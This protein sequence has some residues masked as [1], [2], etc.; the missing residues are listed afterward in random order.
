MIMGNGNCGIAAKPW[1]NANDS[2]NVPQKKSQNEIVLVAHKK[3]SKMLT[4]SASACDLRFSDVNNGSLDASSPRG[5]LD[6]C[7]RGSESEASFKENTTQSESPSKSR[8]L[9]NWSRFFKLWK[10]KSTKHLRTF[11]PLAM[12]KLS[13]EK[14][15]S[16][17]EDPDLTHIYNYR[18]SLKE[19]TL[20]EL[21]TATKN[22]SSE[23]LIGKGGYAE[24]Y[25]GCLRDGTLV[26]VKRLTKG[27]V[28][29]KTCGF[30]CEIGSKDKPDWSKRYRIA[31][32][33]A[34]GLTYLH[35]GCQKRIIH[36]DIK[37]D[38]ILLTEDYEPQ[39]SALKHLTGLSLK[40]KGCTIMRIESHFCRFVILDLRSGCQDS[41]LTTTYFAPEYF[42][43]GIVDEKTDVYSFGVLLLELITGRRAV[44]HLQQSVVIWAKPLLDS[45][46]IRELVDPS[47]GDNYDAEEMDRAVLTASLCIE[48]SPILRPKMSQVVILL[49]GDEDNAQSV[50]ES[51]K[52]THRRT[53]S[54]ELF[55]AQEYN[56]T[57][58]LSDISRF[59]EIAL[60]S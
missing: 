56:S 22:F 45:N 49:R 35:E 5:V 17:R 41:G 46:D 55:D 27:T 4:S 33:T 25:K 2:S 47:L 51:Q 20:S 48:Q 28:D 19:F 14:S 54:E 21:Q 6:S 32:G 39:V 36:R 15:R 52:Q 7:F 58:Y 53:Y 18:S 57:R 16:T 12:P 26:A 23:N 42:M 37:A 9:T 43:H 60:G 59:K 10:K 13:R 29:E 31:L 50:K 30:L 1:N 8:A 40:W 44:D 11:H 24:V 3:Q 38:N 34:N